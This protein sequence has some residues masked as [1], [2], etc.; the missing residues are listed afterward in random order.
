MINTLPIVEAG[1][2]GVSSTGFKHLSCKINSS[3]TKRDSGKLYRYRNFIVQGDC[4]IP[5]NIKPNDIIKVKMFDNKFTSDNIVS[6]NIVLIFLN[7][8]KFRGYKVREI[9]KVHDKKAITFYYNKKGD[10]I[11]SSLPYSLENIKG[12][13]EL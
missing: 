5:R 11:Q 1:P 12:I 7:D 6:G 3:F 9:E 2:T 4:M 10:K 13:V 8:K